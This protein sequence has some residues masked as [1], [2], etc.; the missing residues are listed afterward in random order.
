MSINLINWRVIRERHSINA[1]KILSATKFKSTSIFSHVLA[2]IIFHNFL[3]CSPAPEHVQ[4][5]AFDSSLLAKWHWHDKF[6]IVRSLLA[7]LRHRHTFTICRRSPTIR[8]NLLLICLDFVRM[9][10]CSS[11]KVAL[12]VAVH[13][14]Q[15]HQSTIVDSSPWQWKVVLSI[16]W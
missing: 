11:S 8:M 9:I 14:S 15:P 16:L 3:G 7:P 12:A 5:L 2:F 6:S 10:R 1:L 4:V 13:L